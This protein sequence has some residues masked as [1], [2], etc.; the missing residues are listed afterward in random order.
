MTDMLASCPL[1]DG[2]D[3]LDY[4]LEKEASEQMEAQER[5][6]EI[7]DYYLSF[8]GYN[9]EFTKYLSFREEKMFLGM[10]GLKSYADVILEIKELDT[11]FTRDKLN[12]LKYRVEYKLVCW[13]AYNDLIATEKLLKA[14][15]LHPNYNKRFF[16]IAKLEE[17]PDRMVCKDIAMGRQ[18]FNTDINEPWEKHK[19]LEPYQL[20]RLVERFDRSAKQL[21]GNNGG[22]RFCSKKD[23]HGKYHSEYKT[24]I[25]SCGICYDHVSK[26]TFSLPGLNEM[27]EEYSA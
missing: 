20:I 22:F 25:N 5:D 21:H 8:R 7:L 24:Y 13:Y 19:V 17:L 18:K 12:A 1:Y 6:N 27:D 26:D 11:Y 2:R 9:K 14:F 16:H 15:N 4:I 23:H 3:P 10:M